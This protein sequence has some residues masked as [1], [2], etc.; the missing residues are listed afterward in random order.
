MYRMTWITC[1]KGAVWDCVPASRGRA[2]AFALMAHAAPVQHQAC[3]V[4]FW[5]A[6]PSCHG[7]LCEN[8][9]SGAQT[10]S[11]TPC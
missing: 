6:L 3:R 4:A 11:T 10:G 1:P 2:P 7:C 8:T 5:L 9:D